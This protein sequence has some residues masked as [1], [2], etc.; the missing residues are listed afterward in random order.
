MNKQVEQFYNE[1]NDIWGEP[2][3]YKN[4]S[5]YPLKIS[6]KKYIKL[7]NK[8]L[9][10]PQI[11]LSLENPVIYKMSYLKFLI[12]VLPQVLDRDGKGKTFEEDLKEF[13]SYI[14]KVDIEDI[15]L[16]SRDNDAS[17]ENLIM[18]LFIDEEIFTEADFDNIRDLILL[19]NGS[20]TEY[21]EA[22][23]ESLE[24]DLQFAMRNMDQINFK[25]QVFTFASLFKKSLDEISNITLFQMK[26]LMDTAGTIESYRMQTIPLTH[27]GEKYNFQNYMK[28]I[29]TRGRYDEI[30]KNIDEFREETSYFK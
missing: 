9:G 21:V 30:L 13:L 26:N 23:R 15:G 25:D 14:T 10:Y 24:E 19:Q 6:D 20:S 7:F 12:Y 5:F 4:I 18:S 3:I 16:S 2:Q 1:H 17:I 28:H 22:Y 27:V 11:A 8:L 29:K